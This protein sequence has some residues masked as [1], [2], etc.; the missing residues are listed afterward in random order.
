MVF[1]SNRQQLELM[2]LVP[3]HCYDKTSVLA[4]K[5]RK[6]GSWSFMVKIAD[7]CHRDCQVDWKSSFPMK[8]PVVLLLDSWHGRENHRTLWLLTSEK[9]CKMHFSGLC[10]FLHFFIIQLPLSFIENG[11]ATVLPNVP[12][13]GF[14]TSQRVSRISA[15]AIMPPWSDRIPR[16]RRS[17]SVPAKAFHS[18]CW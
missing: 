8:F 15:G 4:K 13:K 3:S 10:S 11:S 2:K 12:P 18:I 17:E 1:A 7:S 16:L 14:L 9:T 5:R 6:P